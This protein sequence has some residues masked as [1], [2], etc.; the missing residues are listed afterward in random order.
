MPLKYRSGVMKLAHEGLMSAHLGVARTFDKVHSQFYWP[1][2]YQE[3]S[4]F[5]KSCDICQRTL[6]KGKVGKVPLGKVPIIEEPFQRI[7]MDLVGPIVPLSERGNRYILTVIDYATRYPEAV[8]LPNIET[9][10]IAEALVEIYSRMGI[11]SEVLTDMGTQFTSAIMR[12]VSRLLSIKQLCCTPYHPQCNGLIESFHSTLKL[13]LKRLCAERPRDWDR[14]LSALLFAYREAPHESTQFSPFELLY[15]RSVRGPMK[16][17]RDLMTKENTDAEVK[18]TYQYVVD[19]KERLKETCELAHQNLQ[20]AAGRYKKYYDQRK[21]PRTLAV[22]DKVLILLPTDH[23]KLLLQWKGPF[24]VVSKFNDNDYRIKVKGKVKSYH[25]NMLKKYISR[26]DSLQP[27]CLLEARASDEAIEELCAVELTAQ[28]L[29]GEFEN[30]DLM[31]E[32]VPFPSVT[33][34]QTVEDIHVSSDLTE[35]QQSDVNKILSTFSEVFTDVPKQ[36]QV[37]ECDLHLTTDDPIRSKPYPVPQAVRDTM[38]K[39]INDLLSL[40]TIQRSTSSYA[41]PVVMVRKKDGTVCF[42][43][44]FRKLNRVV[45]FDPEPMPNPEHLFVELAH[46]HYFTKIDL[47]KGY[48]QIPMSLNA[49]DKT[50]FVTP[51]GHYEFNFLPFGIVVAPA[52]FTRMM[53]KIFDGVRHVV[54]YIDDI[55]VHTKTWSEHVETLNCVLG[56]LHEANLA[57]KPSKCYIGFPSLEFLGHYVGQGQ[58]ATNPTLI[59]KIQEIQRPVNKKQVRSL[60]GLTGYYRK[61]IPNYSEITVPLSDLTRKGQPNKIKWEDPQEHAFQTLK[62]KLANPPILQLPDFTKTFVLRTDASNRGLGAI[63]MQYHDDILHP[64]AYASRKLSKPEQNYSA[65][66]KECLA[67]IWAIGK[68]DLYLFGR[69]FIIQ[70]DHKPLTY[71][72]QSKCLNKR[73]MHW[74]MTLQEYRFKVESIS[75]KE[76]HGPDFL[77]RVPGNES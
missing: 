63:L 27:S 25:I 37:I 52:V 50:A 5:C 35:E 21:K 40:G 57:A 24:P 56:I 68:F 61:F 59:K 73:I 10:T 76:N 64:I 53:R 19:L 28:T 45:I 66:E 1:H 48:Y 16:V 17:L 72:N 74:A 75:G 7:A 47:T 49:R 9:V 30:D 22:G 12:E 46:D 71:I 33:R 2:M 34:T 51:D 11:P 14:Y 31:T 29:L 32:I 18:T 43:I 4:D 55:L 77:S 26:P 54:S 13:M 62:S 6:P 8:A 58:L 38:K 20:K 65:I 70:T 41:S 3:V 23:N 60:L 67:I 42:C 69:V 36:T 15:G 44:D 39:E